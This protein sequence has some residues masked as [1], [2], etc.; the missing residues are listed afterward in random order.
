[1]HQKA[2]SSDSNYNKDDDDFMQS[3]QSRIQQVHEREAVLP[4]VVLDSMLPRQRLELTV[5]NP[6][7]IELIRQRL[8]DETPYFGMMGMAR[9]ASGQFVHLKNG[10]QVDIVGKPVVIKNNPAAESSQSSLLSSTSSSNDNKSSLGLKIVLKAGRRFRITSPSSVQDAK[11]RGGR[12]GLWTEA[13]VEFLDHDDDES[14]NV[15]PN[16]DRFGLA[17]AI[18]KS[19]ELEPLVTTWIDLVR[20]QNRE[21]QPDQLDMIIRDLGPMPDVDRPSDRA[22]WVGALINPIPA[23]GVAL[24]IRPSLLCACTPEERV[25][26][27]LQGIRG[28]IEHMMQRNPKIE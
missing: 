17:R 28:S 27:A 19:R 3:L 26:I 10:V 2:S 25:D 5:N 9:S 24:E 12:D 23:L 11:R 18:S 22:F 4:L 16:G 14:F 1:M 20:Q 6:A 8:A 13:R 15:D 7:L 21:R